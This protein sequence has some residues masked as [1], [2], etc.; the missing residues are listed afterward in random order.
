LAQSK[1]KVGFLSPRLRLAGAERWMIQLARHCDPS[2]IEWTGV[3][4]TEWSTE[5]T[6][7]C[8]EM[9]R[10]MPIFGK[11]VDPNSSNHDHRYVK[12]IGGTAVPS[13]THVMSVSDVMITWDA[14]LLPVMTQTYL[15]RGMKVVLVSHSDGPAGANIGMEAGATHFAAVSKAALNVFSAE[16]QKKATVIFNGAEPERCCP[17]IGRDKMRER[18]GIK[19]GTRVVGYIGRFSEEK[20]PLASAL[21][22]QALPAEYHAVF[23]GPDEMNGFRNHVL[24]LIP[25]ERFTICPP[26]WHIGDYLAAF[27]CLMVASGTEA[28]SLRINEAWLAGCPVISTPIGCIPEVEALHDSM[29]MQVPYQERFNPKALAMCVEGIINYMDGTMVKRAREV[30]WANYT[31]PACAQ[32]W[33]DYIHSLTNTVR[34]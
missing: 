19:P 29:V 9:N 20:N 7:M 23:V 8:R 21:A 26:T 2:V 3:T 22:L 1:I 14:N 24:K 17:A 33:T 10:Y 11:F 15:E 5:D 32:R 13:L 31:A 4:L 30:A 27:D 18:L 6:D 16:A 25:Q 12:R 28:F 34:S